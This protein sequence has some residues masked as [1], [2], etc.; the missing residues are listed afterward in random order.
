MTSRSRVV[1]CSANWKSLFARHRFGERFLFADIDE[2]L[3]ALDALQLENAMLHP[4]I[5]F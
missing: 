4:R 3:P 2:D 1:V 5:V